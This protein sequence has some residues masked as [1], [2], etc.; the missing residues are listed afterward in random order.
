M[1]SQ[2]V[3]L[4]IT[5]YDEGSNSIEAYVQRVK[6]DGFKDTCLFFSSWLS[7]PLQSIDTRKRLA[8]SCF[9]KVAAQAGFAGAAGW[10]AAFA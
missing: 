7:T 10:G 3:L 6:A 2:V 8:A 1:D 9:C 4:R 5:D